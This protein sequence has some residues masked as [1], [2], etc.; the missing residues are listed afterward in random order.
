MTPLEQLEA[1]LAWACPAQPS[2][3]AEA[4][5]L[6]RLRERW[7]LGGGGEGPRDMA[8]LEREWFEAGGSYGR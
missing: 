6:H 7:P 4:P 1:C 2:S 5:D 8:A 3:M